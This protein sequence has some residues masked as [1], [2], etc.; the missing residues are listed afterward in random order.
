VSAL[1]QAQPAD[2]TGPSLADLAE[3][4]IGLARRLSAVLA[5]EIDAV[6]GK[7][8]ASLTELIEEKEKLSLAY[9][10]AFKRW[11]ANPA[12]R[13]IAPAVFSRLREAVARLRRLIEENAKI[14]KIAK[15]AHEK[16]IKAVSDAVIEKARPNLSYSRHGALPAAEQ[17]AAP[18]SLALDKT[19]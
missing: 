13:A 14:L 8:P 12:P 10:T 18:P 6:R 4:I 16:L 7:R 1:A 11:P 9:T 15:V 19:V 2:A 3:T 5:A 17:N